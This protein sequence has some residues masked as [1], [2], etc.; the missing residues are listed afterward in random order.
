MD[1]NAFAAARHF[2]HAEA[3]LLER[4]IFDC[5]FEDGRPEQVA[6]A[7]RGYVNLDGGFGQGLE[8]DKRAPDSQPLDVQIAYEAMQAVGHVDAG[9]VTSACD[10]L[11]GL[12]PAPPCVLPSVLDHPHAPHWAESQDSPA[13]NPTAAIAGLLWDFDIDHPWRKAA[14]ELCWNE[15]AAATP[16]EA[17]TFR[18]VLTF[19]AHVPDRDRVTALWPGLA[20][21]VADLRPFH[22]DPASPGYGLTPLH[23][24]PTPTSVGRPLFTD[25]TIARHLD[26]LEAAQQPDGGWPLSWETIGPSATAEWRGAETLRALCALR[27]YHRLPQDPA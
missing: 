3:R 22:H 21:T 24:A 9:L 14:T 6:E 5:L 20:T 16:P 26:A 1:R 12:G 23:L 8:P 4:L 10:W 13:L 2:I 25:A 15:L 27:A 18:C 19:L 11:Q 17:H 7:L